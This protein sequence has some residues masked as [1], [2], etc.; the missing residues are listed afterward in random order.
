[1]QA[2]LENIA[3]MELGQDACRV[4]HGRGCVFPH[5]E[6]LCL[7]WFP[8]VLL[9]TSFIA[10]SEQDLAKIQTVIQNRFDTLFLSGKITDSLNLVYQYRAG[11]NSQTHILA[12]EVPE[13][14][15]VSENDCD[16]LVHLSKGQN[17]GLFLDMANGRKW[18]KDHAV[19]KKVLNLFSYTCAFSIAALK[20]GAES[21]VNIDMAKGALS[22][23][24]QN[25]SLNDFNGR[26]SFLGH[27]IFKSWGKLRKNG[28]YD[29][30]VADPPSNQKGSFVATKDYVRL[31]RRLPEL[32]ATNCQLLL[33]LNAPELSEDYFKQQIAQEIPELTLV[34]RLDNPAAFVDIDMNKALKVLLYKR[35]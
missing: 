17:H 21:V 26:A 34:E 35:N 33:C 4:F 15:V 10:L 8:P 32:M 28:P 1:M 20:G 2:F 13:K 16:Y 27:D 30:I 6:H 9:L 5:C 3:T 11:S 24:K 23:G 14:H 18:L 12:G 31:L 7:D 19:D 29:I 25:H 22:I